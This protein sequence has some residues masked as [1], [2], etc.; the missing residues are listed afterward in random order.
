MTAIK[1]AFVGI[2]A[3]SWIWLMAGC[4]EV[5]VPGTLAGGGE[6]YRYST[7]N[8]AKE[9]FIGN[10]DQVTA[11]PCR[12]WV[13]NCNPSAPIFLWRNSAQ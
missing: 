3:I 5:P 10:V 11:A 8:V 9:T 13:F 2:A 12:R 4:A 6:A 1:K 7:A